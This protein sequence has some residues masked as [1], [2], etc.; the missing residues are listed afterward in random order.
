MGGDGSIPPQ[1]NQPVALIRRHPILLDRF[2]GAGVSS[3]IAPAAR[4]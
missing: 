4:E 1:R 3:V 2:L